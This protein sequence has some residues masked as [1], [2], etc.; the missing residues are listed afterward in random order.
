MRVRGP[1]SPVIVRSVSRANPIHAG[2]RPA[3]RRAARPRTSRPR[4][5]L[6]GDNRGSRRPLRSRAR[7][8]A[9]NLK[10]PE[11]PVVSNGSFLHNLGFD[12]R[13]ARD[14]RRPFRGIPFH[15]RPIK[16]SSAAKSLASQI[17]PYLMTSA[18]T[19]APMRERQRLEQ[20]RVDPH[21]KGLIKAPTR[22]FPSG[23]STAVLPPA[24]HPPAP[25]GGR[26]LH[27][28]DAAQIGR[29]NKPCEVA[30]DSSA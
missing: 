18:E 3:A 6:R 30:Y 5:L 2:D 1:G 12:L 15:P 16:P 29:G 22:F 20:R 23:I 25:E 17:A 4:S 21:Q 13:A 19:V 28:R 10:S 27:I 11:G 14:D 9:R 8:N 7:P 26:D 24:R